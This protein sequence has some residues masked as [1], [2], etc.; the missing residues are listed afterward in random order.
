MADLVIGIVNFILGWKDIIVKIFS[1]YPFTAA[2]VSL[3]YLVA[4]IRYY[5]DFFS[6]FCQH[7]NVS[8]EIT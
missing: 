2:L 6:Q 7:L 4:L 8:E 1:E 5:K 3:V